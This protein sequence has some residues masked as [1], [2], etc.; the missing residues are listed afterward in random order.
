MAQRPPT[1]PLPWEDWAEHLMYPHLINMTAELIRDTTY[2]LRHAEKI[3]DRHSHSITYELGF[4]AA[5]IQER[6][7]RMLKIYR[8]YADMKA[9]EESTYTVPELMN[10]YHVMQ[11]DYNEIRLEK[12]IFHDIVR[13]YESTP[14]TT[15]PGPPRSTPGGRRRVTWR[16]NLNE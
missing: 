1:E 11:G 8:K 16:S 13:K 6:F 4:I 3:K 12:G 15:P 9:F 5:G 10:A 7:Q 2:K 14:P